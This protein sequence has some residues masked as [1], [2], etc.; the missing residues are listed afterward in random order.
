MLFVMHLMP[1]MCHNILITAAAIFFM[2]FLSPL[3]GNGRHC[4][5]S[6]SRTSGTLC[7]RPART[8]VGGATVKGSFSRWCL[9]LSVVAYSRSSAARLSVI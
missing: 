6:T 1:F 8:E 9:G 2:Y 4:P 5:L 7:A 3:S